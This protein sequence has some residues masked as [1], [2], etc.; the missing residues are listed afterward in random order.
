MIRRTIALIVAL[1]CLAAVPAG[2]ATIPYSYDTKTA[3]KVPMLVAATTGSG[4]VVNLRAVNREAT[5]T[6][7]WTTGCDAGVVTVEVA[8]SCDYAGTWTSW[9]V[10]PF[11]YG[12]LTVPREDQVA[13]GHAVGC[14]RTRVSTTVTNGTVSTWLSAVR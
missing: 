5:V 10:V 1:A 6:I 11:N 7:S 13:I 3:P 9:A 4:D 2:A 14:V 12:G 8:K